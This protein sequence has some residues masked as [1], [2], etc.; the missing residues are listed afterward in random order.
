MAKSKRMWK[1]RQA[2][3]ATMAAMA[4]NSVGISLVGL[5]FLKK[6]GHHPHG[7]CPPFTLQN[8]GDAERCLRLPLGNDPRA[9][10]NRYHDGNEDSQNSTTTSAEEQA[11]CEARDEH[12][13]E[14]ADDL[15]DG[16]GAIEKALDDEQRFQSAPEATPDE[17]EEDGEH[18][19][20]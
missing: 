3:A 11:G 4:M 20:T 10:V 5:N 9:R 1:I 17:S 8:P 7:W 15:G 14:A 16:L 2:T 12:A 13:E 18:D 19:G 6:V